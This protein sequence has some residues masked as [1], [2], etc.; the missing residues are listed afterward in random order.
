MT[1][2]CTWAGFTEQLD[3]IRNRQTANWLHCFNSKHQSKAGW[4]VIYFEAMELKF[5]VQTASA[6]LDQFYEKRRLLIL[7]APSIS[8]PDYQLQN[9]MIQ[10]RIALLFTILSIVF[11]RALM[12]RLLPSPESWL[13]IGPSTRHGDRTAGVPTSRDGTR[14]RKSAGVWSHRGFE[15]RLFCGSFWE[16]A[17]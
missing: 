14:Q 8:D 11:Y 5:S 3:S 12:N 4:L 13:W 6:L 17:D 1:D 10:A 16:R 15:V 9:I 2:S 7:S